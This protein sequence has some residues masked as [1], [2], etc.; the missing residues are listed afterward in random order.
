MGNG[1]P[2]FIIGCA[3]SGSG[4]LRLA[5]D[6]HERIAIAPETGFMR[7][8]RASRF[9]PFWP[10]GGRW[11]RR[12][13]LTEEQLDDHLRRFYEGL[14]RAYAERQGKT[15]WGE[16][17]PWHVWHVEAMARLFPDAVFLA[18]VRHP[19]GNA[20]SSVRRR[21]LGFGAAVGEWADANAEIA[22]RA[23][24]LGDRFAVLR[25]EDL[26]LDP[27]RSL[28]SL[29]AWLGED[30][31]EGAQW[32]ADGLD[33]T[34]VSHW[35]RSVG[36]PR[37]ARLERRA[38]AL[39]ELFGYSLDEP[40]AGDPLGLLRGG[41]IEARVARL[42]GLELATPPAVPLTERLYNP[43]DVQLRAVEPPPAATAPPVPPRPGWLRRVVRPVARRLPRSVRRALRG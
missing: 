11:Y 26:V 9:V 40:D 28:R 36:A 39:V 22:R 7:I 5:L 37:R 15:R 33:R 25:Y 43:R 32:D 29:F 1:G 6:R 42:P 27:E 3:G 34:R 24:S 16:S 30:W 12:L 31:P 35:T 41:D 13:G 17:T 23:V 20:V 19:A 18:T 10:F 2:I 38:G 14:F 8:E 21:G 4:L